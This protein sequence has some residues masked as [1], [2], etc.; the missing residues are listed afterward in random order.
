MGRAAVPSLSARATCALTRLARY[1]T[2]RASWVLSC[3]SCSKSSFLMYGTAA[4][5]S[6]RYLPTLMSPFRRPLCSC[7]THIEGH[8]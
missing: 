3:K 4:Q 7:T 8:S 5:V 1:I 6:A 2:S